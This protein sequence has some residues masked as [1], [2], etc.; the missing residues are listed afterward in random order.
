MYLPS[1]WVSLSGP[2]QALRDLKSQIANLRFEILSE[3]R[4]PCARKDIMI[5]SRLGGNWK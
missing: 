2:M 1:A 3:A 4:I 5:A